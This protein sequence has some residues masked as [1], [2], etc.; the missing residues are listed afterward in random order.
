MAGNTWQTLL[1]LK[2]QLPEL[3]CLARITQA[4]WA[5]LYLGA[6]AVLG[7]ASGLHLLHQRPQLGV[8]VAL[9]APGQAHAQALVDAVKLLAA[10]LADVL[11]G[12]RA[13]APL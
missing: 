6:I 4:A 11:P 13:A 12:L 3:R 2:A 10:G 5:K 7:D 9:A 8:V 1:H